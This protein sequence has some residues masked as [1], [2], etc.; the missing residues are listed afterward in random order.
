MGRGGA[1]PP[2]CSKEVDQSQS[3]LYCA[4]YYSQYAHAYL[5]TRR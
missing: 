2:Q 1:H 3:T 4:V 5:N